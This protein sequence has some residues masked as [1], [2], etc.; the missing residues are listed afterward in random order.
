M[1]TPAVTPD[2]RQCYHER[3]HWLAWMLLI[4]AAVA[5]CWR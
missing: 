4:G 1:E 2:E 3:L 5:A